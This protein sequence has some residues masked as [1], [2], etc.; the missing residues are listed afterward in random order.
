MSY[1]LLASRTKLVFSLLTA[2]CLLGILATA[3]QW[4]KL[5]LPIPAVILFGLGAIFSA[6]LGYRVNREFKKLIVAA[7]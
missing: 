3:Q 1:S 6:A 2:F 5:L 4:D 7:V